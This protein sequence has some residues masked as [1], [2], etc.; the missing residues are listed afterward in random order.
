MTYPLCGLSQPTA[1]TSHP[2]SWTGAS[3]AHTHLS[4]LGRVAPAAV[5]ATLLTGSHHLLLEPPGEGTLL[6]QCNL[7][8]GS[9]WGVGPTALGIY[10]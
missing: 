9:Q 5:E 2:A 6:L 3:G 8:L 1:A 10:V 7:L 4:G